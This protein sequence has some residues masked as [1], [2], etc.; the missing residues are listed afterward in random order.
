MQRVLHLLSVAARELDENS[1]APPDE[2]VV[3]CLQAVERVDCVTVEEFAF[4]GGAVVFPGGVDEE[5][6][7]RKQPPFCLTIPTSGR[8]GLRRERRR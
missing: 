5:V 4:G 6:G 8:C 1:F 3:D 2:L 7:G